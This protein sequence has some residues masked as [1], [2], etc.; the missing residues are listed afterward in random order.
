[1]ITEAHVQK[2]LLDGS[3]LDVVATGI[4]YLHNGEIKTA[5]VREA[6]VVILAAGVMHSL[7]YWSF[8]D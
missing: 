5:N 4:G 7:N 2:V 3:F 1:M 8:P 6:G